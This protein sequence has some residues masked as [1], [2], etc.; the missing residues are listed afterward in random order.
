MLSLYRTVINIAWLFSGSV[1]LA[2][3]SF[4]EG[5]IIAR[6]LGPSGL[7]RWG[8]IVSF[9]MLVGGFLTFRTPDALVKELIRFK[10]E[11]F[12]KDKL[13]ALFS[14]AIAVDT[15]SGLLCVVS[16][17]ILAPW[18]GSR[19]SDDTSILLLYPLY[20]LTLVGTSLE[21]IWSSVARDRKQFR[22]LGIVPT[23]FAALRAIL[24]VTIWK[25]HALTLP[26]IITACVAVSFLRGLFAVCYL[27]ASMKYYDLPVTALLPDIK[28]L[29]HSA[30][31]SFWSYM[32]FGYISGVLSSFMKNA[33][34]LILGWYRPDSEIGLY[35][36]AKSLASVVQ[37]LSSATTTVY[38]QKFNELVVQ[39]PSYA[40]NYINSTF[41]KKWYLTLAGGGI[42]AIVGAHFFIPLV[43]GEPFREVVTLFSILSIG[44]I[45]ALAL[46]W[47]QS[48]L[49]ALG[50]FQQNF[51]VLLFTALCILSA[52][53]C[54]VPIYGATIMAILQSLMW[55]SINFC[56]YRI[57]RSKF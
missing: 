53:L 44:V 24:I 1:G 40:G 21:G 32:R 6:A 29:R 23:L 14:A 2:L 7:G 49:L 35:R 18:C 51:Y 11:D 43:Y 30:L 26:L 22:V 55:I 16:I 19:L 54:L 39:S 42:L 12:R 31:N 45:V 56:F 28:L 27:A 50:G 47:T 9:V 38:Y 46:F 8:V 4:G 33:D 37:S 15:L 52:A 25:T 13:R 57:L 17:A 20:A 10:S 48:M 3:V 5:V 34:M 41:G 36:L